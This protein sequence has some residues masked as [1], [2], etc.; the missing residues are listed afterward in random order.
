MR[1]RYIHTTHIRISRMSIF[2][3]FFLQKHCFI[4]VSLFAERLFCAAAQQEGSKTQ[5]ALTVFVYMLKL[6]TRPAYK[7][8][9]TT[10]TLSLFYPL[11]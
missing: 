3:S 10:T 7:Y 5:L 1:V 6:L 8:F 11:R 4:S 2:S 9:A